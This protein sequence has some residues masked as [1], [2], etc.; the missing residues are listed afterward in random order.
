MADDEFRLNELSRYTKSSPRLVLKEYSHCEVPAGCGG[1]VLR[2][3]KPPNTVSF[4]IW[5]HTTGEYEFF[6]DGKNPQSACPL[7]EKGKH[8]LALQTSISQSNYGL[9]MFAGSY[10]E[11]IGTGIFYQGDRRTYVLSLPDTS[12]KYSLIGQTDQSWLDSGFNDASWKAMIAKKLPLLDEHDS[13]Q[14]KIR[15]LEEFGAKSLGIEETI[16]GTVWVRK[17]FKI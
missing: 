12:W 8:V 3:M 1:V 16:T 5:L 2:W 14:Y 15:R 17:I 11:E 10:T 6:I 4:E 7:L 9:L 13:K